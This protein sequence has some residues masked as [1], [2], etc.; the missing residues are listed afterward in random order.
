MKRLLIVTALIELGAGLA[1]MCCPSLAVAL[2]IGSGL[3]TSA[4]VTLGRVAGAV[5]FALGLVCWLAPDDTRSRAARGLRKLH[6]RDHHGRFDLRLP[7][8]PALRC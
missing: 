4:A 2:L 5:L 1:L 6:L 7:F 3:D 8:P